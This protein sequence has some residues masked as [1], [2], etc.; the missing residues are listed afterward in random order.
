MEVSL[1]ISEKGA[2]FRIKPALTFC[3]PVLMIE[4]Q[5]GT[6]SMTA[7]DDAL[8]ELADALHRHLQFVGYYE[9]PDSDRILA[10]ECEATI[11]AESH[12]LPLDQRRVG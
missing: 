7:S 11:E 4:S 1:D 2:S 3:P 10:A 8:A 5:A 6:V 9:Q 12:E